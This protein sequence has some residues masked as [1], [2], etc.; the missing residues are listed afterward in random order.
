MHVTPVLSRFSTTAS[1]AGPGA[2]DRAPWSGKKPLSPPAR[3]YR[4]IIG[5]H[6]AASSGAAAG[7]GRGASARLYTAARSLYNAARASPSTS[8]EAR[9]PPVTDARRRWHVFAAVAIGTFMAT[10]D[11]SIVN[12]SLPTISRDFGIDLSIAQ[13]VVLAY[14][15]TV[16]ALLLPA[17]SFVDLVGR[18][19]SF[20]AGLALFTLGSLACGVAPS[21]G[22]LIA[23]R[24]LQAIGAA[25]TMA[26]GAALLL[27][28]WSPQQRGQVM[29][30]MGMIVSVGLMTGP[31]LGGLISGSLGWRWVFYV[32]LPVGVIG[33]AWAVLSLRG[34]REPRGRLEAFDIP[35]A[36]ALGLFM[37]A[38]C[39]GLTF[40]PKQGWGRP[41][42]AG[43]L[44]A[45]PVLLAGFL[46]RQA[47]AR[48]PMLD[49][50][51]FR[52]ATFSSASAASLLS[53]T[54]Q[55]PIFLFL[56]F[57]LQN[58]AGYSE[59]HTGLTIFIVPLLTAVLAPSSGHLS[60]R[61]GTLWPSV[62]GMVLRAASCG[63][64][65]MLGRE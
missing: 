27:D 8:Q 3:S 57:Y 45:S 10:L 5:V 43:L 56:P 22:A 17:G 35:G 15:M 7:R 25:L 47:T 4:A 6:G 44:V 9:T 30:L 55:F 16:A 32:N 37:I 31:P 1:R 40:G 33:V 42:V 21:E 39:L 58:V 64:L 12:V 48:R 38:L 20:T 54:G 61:W 19:R 18:A 28:V 53:F 60:D 59:T 51:L 24:V 13:W 34:T 23:A 65:L 62:A 41:M 49:L 29:G 26:T 14:L 50:G 63:A 52:N 36:A 11:S 46:W 2:S